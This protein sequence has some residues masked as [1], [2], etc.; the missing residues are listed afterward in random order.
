MYV[1]EKMPVYVN[2]FKQVLI[3]EGDGEI[4]PHQISEKYPHILDKIFLLWADPHCINIYFSELLT[5][6]RENRAG[7]PPEVYAELF[8]LESF[9]TATH[10]VPQKNNDFW[11]TVNKRHQS[12][13]LY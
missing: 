1:T 3:E 7:F 2:A 9:Y 10:P 11:G 5:T 4:F 13:N 12:S 8:A 6:V